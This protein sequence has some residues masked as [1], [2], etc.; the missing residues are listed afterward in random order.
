MLKQ[1]WSVL[2]LLLFTRGAM[3]FQFQSIAAFGPLIG[4]DLALTPGQTGGLIGL[5]MLPG[6]AMAIPGA[7]LGRWLGGKRAALVALALMAAGG[8]ALAGSASFAA[9][10]LAR[11][12][13]GA[14]M[15]LLNVLVTKMVADR[16]RGRESATAMSLLLVMWPVGIALALLTLGG[17]ASATTWRVA[18]SVTGAWPVAA[19]MGMAVLYA[20]MTQPAETERPAGALHRAP[21]PGATGGV[22]P[23]LARTI[24]LGSAAGWAWTLY[25]CGFTALISFA[26]ALLA[27]RGASLAEAGLISSFF[28]WGAMAGTPAGGVFADA[29][30]KPRT[31]VLFAS[32]SGAA[33]IALAYAG[34]SIVHF[35]A[36][37]FCVCLPTGP[38]MAMLGEALPE[39][40]RSLGYGVLLSWY[41]LGVGATPALAGLLQEWTGTPESILPLSAALVLATYPAYRGFHGLLRRLE[42]RR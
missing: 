21:A 15:V 32:L 41:Y 34:N 16:F 23:R 20:D 27:F 33:L 24:L 12:V 28:V 3:G 19:L 14:G 30:R 18:A 36:M 17:L 37:G 31:L 6:V 29:T 39:R 22:R 40:E 2:A 4:R 7:L 10:A 35:I 9:A 1:R 8:F 25:N 13:A 42:G 38:L 11:L 26:P 5:Y